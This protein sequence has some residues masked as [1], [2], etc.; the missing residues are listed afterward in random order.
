VSDD[1]PPTIDAADD[2]VTCPRCRVMRPAVVGACPKCSL[3]ALLAVERYRPTPT[4]DPARRARIVAALA[5]NHDAREANR[6]Q[7]ALIRGDEDL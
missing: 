4:V 1:Q 2:Y 7:A 5:E 6:R 3:T